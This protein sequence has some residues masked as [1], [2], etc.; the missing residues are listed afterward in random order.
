MGRLAAMPVLVALVERAALR[1]LWARTPRRLSAVLAALAATPGPLVVARR[2]RRAQLA[3]RSAVL[4]AL[5]ATAVPVDLAGIAEP[6]AREAVAAL[7][8]AALVVWALRV[9]VARAAV[10]VRAALASMQAH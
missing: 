9:R 4:A 2:A 6:A 3:L 7:D 8:Q 5:A 10:V 1:A